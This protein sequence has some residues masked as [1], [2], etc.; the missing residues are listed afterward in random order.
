[1]STLEPQGG[2]A[3]PIAADCAN[4]YASALGSLLQS[5]NCKATPARA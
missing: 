2:T 3:P 5:D 4:A 1:M